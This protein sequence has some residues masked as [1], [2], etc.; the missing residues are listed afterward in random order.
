MEIVI[1]RCV[2]SDSD[3]LYTLNSNEMGYFYPAEQTTNQ[4]STILNDSTNAV[5]VAVNGREVIGY[6]HGAVY[7]ILYADPMVNVLGIAVC[8]RYRRMG[9][10]RALLDA[11][12]NW[13][14]ENGISSM[15]L[16]S[17]AERTS[18][19]EFYKKCGYVLKKSQL[20]FK[21]NI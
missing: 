19:H 7:N 18:A 16:T 20:N 2:L 14:L 15:R 3:S 11:L 13:A 10:G 6:I 4:L 9:V 1:R 12:E 21:K 8:E 17:G 5:F